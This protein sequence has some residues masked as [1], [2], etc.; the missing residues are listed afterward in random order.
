MREDGELIVVGMLGDNGRYDH[1]CK[2]SDG[3]Y[4]LRDVGNLFQ[5]DL[6]ALPLFL[7]YDGD[8]SR[9]D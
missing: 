4:I 1:L 6:I 3:S 9:V 2:G 5:L 7:H 8:G